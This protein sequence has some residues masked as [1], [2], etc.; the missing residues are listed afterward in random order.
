[1]AFSTCHKP[2]QQQIVL[3]FFIGDL[4]SYHNKKKVFLERGFHVI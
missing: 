4:G 2:K 3:N 1:M